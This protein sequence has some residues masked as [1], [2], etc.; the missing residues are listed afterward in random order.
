M[1]S[2]CE[3]FVS[4]C[5][6]LYKLIYTTTCLLLSFVFETPI[7]GHKLFIGRISF[8]SV[9]NVSLSLPDS[10][11]T[12]SPAT[13][14]RFT[15]FSLH[16]RLPEFRTPTPPESEDQFRTPPPTFLTLNLRS[17]L[18]TSSFSTVSTTHTT[19]H[20]LLYP[21]SWPHRTTGSP[22][23]HTTLRG[24][25][26]RIFSSTHTP[27]NV[28]RLR[29]A[30]VG[31]IVFGEVLRFAEFRTKVQFGPDFI[32]HGQEMAGP[33]VEK[34]GMHD[35]DADGDG[36]NDMYGHAQD[37]EQDPDDD[38][39]SIDGCDAG[40]LARD[41]P[42]SGHDDL[43]VTAHAASLHMDDLKGR[44]YAFDEVT[45]CLRRT[46]GAYAH[47]TADALGKQ[48]RGEYEMTA[49]GSRWVR[50]PMVA[51][52]DQPERW[53]RV[54]LANMR[55]VLLTLPYTLVTDPM[56]HVDLYVPD[57]HIRFDDF[58][59][60][61]AELVRQGFEVAARTYAYMHA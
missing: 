6:F 17:A 51:L 14:I 31:T 53:W 55:F 21:T 57:A 43:F 33:G 28:Q 39:D 23:V 58:R 9:G 19:V 20:V 38:D 56:L 12:I 59:I 40:P 50:M 37:A 41:A 8:L 49:E 26:L 27:Y 16:P 32:G 7:C 35:G 36:H 10:Q 11:H 13:N 4:A 3:G 61:D 48:S 45:A 46:W 52:R 5:S 15:S 54:W 44:V 1:T 60:R 25:R 29:E 24:F 2:L 22:F 34:M 42:D 30:L 18:L 47:D